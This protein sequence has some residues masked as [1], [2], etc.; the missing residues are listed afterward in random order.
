MKKT[1]IHLADLVHDYI[2]K[3][4]F[5]FPLNIGYISAHTYSIFGDSVEIRLFKK[6]I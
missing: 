6:I 5:V 1:L 4:P 2:S 3:G